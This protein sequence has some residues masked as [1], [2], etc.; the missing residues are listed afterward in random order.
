MREMILIKRKN[1]EIFHAHAHTVR[2]MIQQK[3]RGFNRE[4]YER[5]MPALPHDV[6]KLPFKKHSFFISIT[7][8]TCSLLFE[9]NHLAVVKQY[10]HSINR[11]SL[12]SKDLMHSPYLRATIR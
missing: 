4:R 9:G 3:T 8:Y 12:S 10:V 2:F 11:C 7:F 6:P 5:G 1:A